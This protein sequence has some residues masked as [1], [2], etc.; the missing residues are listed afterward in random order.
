[1]QNLFL[2]PALDQKFR[3][4][5]DGFLKICLT[6]LFLAVGGV[7]S[8]SAETVSSQ[9]AAAEVAETRESVRQDISYLNTPPE[10]DYAAAQCKL[11]VYLP[12]TS[13]EPAPLLVWFHGGALKGGSKT[14]KASVAVA[15]SLADRGVAVVLPEYRFSPQV[16][17]PAYLRDAA[18]AVRWAVDHAESLKVR[19]KIY[20]GGHSA[21]GY[22]AALL[23]MDGRF[24]EEAGVRPDRIAGF[25]NMSGQTMTHFTVAEERGI[26]GTGVTAD[27]AAPIHH[28]RKDI[29]PL[30]VLIADNDWPARR[31]E[32]AYFVQAMRDV[33][34]CKNLSF[35]IVGNRDHSSILKNT[36]EIDDPAATAIL[37]FVRSGSL[38][39]DH[40]PLR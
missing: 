23:A 19:P 25:I 38:P 7:V 1:M 4:L 22:L 11:D 2:F 21:G 9:L 15:K 33:A 29:A 3:R 30:L 39:P 34:G 28:L 32:N 40:T 6:L 36:A 17:F 10:N 31:E 20:V 37:D 24:L 27:E 18:Q 5:S 8:S 16:T 35:R 26:S 13:G 14:G 12:K